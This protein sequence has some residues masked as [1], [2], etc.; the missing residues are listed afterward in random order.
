MNVSFILRICDPYLFRNN[1][2]PSFVLDLLIDRECR[3]ICDS[4]LIFRPDFILSFYFD[5]MSF[6]WVFFVFLF[7]QT[8]DK[9]KDQG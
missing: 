1:L 9:V 8:N 2:H 4:N 5:Y 6:F 7:L 3:R